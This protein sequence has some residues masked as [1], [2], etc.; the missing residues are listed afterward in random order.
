VFAND[1]IS[2]GEIIERCPFIELPAGEIAFLEKSFLINYVYFFGKTKERFLLALGFGSLYNHSY[3]PNAVY[4]ILPKEHI[5]L[6]KAIHS[7]TNDE[8]I[9]V[10]YVQGNHPK[11]TLWFES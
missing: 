9:T 2:K 8:E 11:V 7:I 5:I 1:T 10:N 6:F 3:T 4:K